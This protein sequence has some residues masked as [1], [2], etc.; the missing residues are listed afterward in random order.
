MTTISLS[1]DPPKLRDCIGNVREKINFL[2]TEAEKGQTTVELACK[3]Q[4]NR[5]DEVNKYKQFL[6][7]TEIWLQ[8]I[9]SGINENRTRNDWKVRF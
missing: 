5:Q 4:E 1:L 9:V 2:I 6:E 8:S 7:D 3:T